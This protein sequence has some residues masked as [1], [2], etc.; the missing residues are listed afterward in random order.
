MKD[1]ISATIS[2]TCPKY[3]LPQD[4]PRSSLD[5]AKFHFICHILLLLSAVVFV[6]TKFYEMSSSRKWLFLKS[7]TWTYSVAISVS[8]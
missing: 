1:I 8:S 5:L 4:Y 6:V 2:P 7:G 3:I